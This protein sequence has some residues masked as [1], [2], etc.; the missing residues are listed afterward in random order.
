[1]CVTQAF[2]GKNLCTRKI[3][4]CLRKE[5]TTTKI[6]YNVT[7]TYRKTSFYLS[8]WKRKQAWKTDVKCFKTNALCKEKICSLDLCKSS[9]LVIM[10]PALKNRFFITIFTEIRQ[11]KKY[12]EFKLLK[13]TQLRRNGFPFRFLLCKIK[14]IQISE[15]VTLKTR[16]RIMTNLVRVGQ[17]GYTRFCIIYTFSQA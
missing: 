5:S 15:E 10:P 3:S 1:M 2:T 16:K 6:W 12:R 4:R 11:K 7:W 17:V 9:Y 13:V 14:N 8:F